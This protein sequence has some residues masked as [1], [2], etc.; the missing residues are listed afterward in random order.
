VVARQE[1]EPDALLR[2]RFGVPPLGVVVLGTLLPMVIAALGNTVPCARGVRA[3]RY[4]PAM[5]PAGFWLRLITRGVGI[6]PLVR[7]TLGAR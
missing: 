1:G 4:L 5:L 2:G 3:V 7:L 6:V